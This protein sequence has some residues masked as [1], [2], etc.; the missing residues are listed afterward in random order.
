MSSKP[1]AELTRY[2]YVLG[3]MGASLLCGGALGVA[4]TIPFSIASGVASV[5]ATAMLL[6]GTVGQT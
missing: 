5:V 2:D 6:I 1:F 3:G 4:S